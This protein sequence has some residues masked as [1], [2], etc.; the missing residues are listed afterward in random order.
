MNE[1]IK[2]EENEIQKASENEGL[3]V[4]ANNQLEEVRLSI[5]QENTISIP[6]AELSSLGTAICSMIPSLRKVTH[7]I[8]FATDGLYRIV[9]AETGD[10]L[11]NA[12]DGKKGTSKLAKLSEAESISGTV[13]TFRA[14]L[15]PSTMMMAAALYSIQKEL[16][17]IE[18]MQRQIIS[19]L[20]FEKESEIEA[21][22]ETL[23]DIAKKY[24]LNWDNEHF[25]TSNHKQML[26]I[27]RTAR[28]NMIAYQ[29]QVDAVIEKKRLFL[30]QGEINR[31]F[32]DLEKK[33]KYYRLSL[34]SYSLSSF[35][36]IMLSGNFKEAYI[37]G[38]KAEILDR[39]FQYRN[40][41]DKGSL[42]LEKLGGSVLESYLLK[43]VGVAGET[44]GKVIGNIPYI[45]DGNVDEFLQDNGEKIIKNAS[46]LK[47][48]AV[49]DFSLLNNPGTGMI[50]NKLNDMNR[51]YNHTAEI[52]VD[53]NNIYL[54]QN[55][56]QNI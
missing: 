42:Y 19:F 35:M 37:N 39:Q 23:I 44:L 56:K 10:I 5:V 24:T 47:T 55:Q 22:I 52:C 4:D 32:A 34:Y 12:K 41:F 14:P 51:I 31:I 54:V 46:N 50:I 29:K 48:K 2:K 9:N 28:K 38:V 27:Q 1:I 53:Q 16:S 30:N 15:D 36:E 43:G 6:I 26:D 49:Y 20:Q 25:V 18:E 40:L 7:K 3:L 33:F 13:E 8:S 11:K 45:K 17:N 21:D